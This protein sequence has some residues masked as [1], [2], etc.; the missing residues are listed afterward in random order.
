MLEKIVARIKAYFVRIKNYFTPDD[1]KVVEKPTAPP[2]VTSVKSAPTIRQRKTLA[3]VKNN[4]T[5]K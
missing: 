3:K 4:N 5:K 2:V 1:Q